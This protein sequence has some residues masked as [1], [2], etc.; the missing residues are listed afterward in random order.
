MEEKRAKDIAYGVIDPTSFET[1]PIKE[2]EMA[3]VYKV[4]K[5]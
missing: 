3:I 1:F 4:L 2:N 5:R